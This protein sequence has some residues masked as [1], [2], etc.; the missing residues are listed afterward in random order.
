MNPAISSSAE[1]P[2]AVVDNHVRR[3]CRAT[4][5]A[6]FEV[7]TGKVAAAHKKRRRA[8]SSSIS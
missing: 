7:A 8:S 5:F 1:R 2:S 4:L 6:A 3:I